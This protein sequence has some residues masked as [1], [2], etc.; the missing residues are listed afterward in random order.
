MKYDYLLNMAYE[1]YPKGID[2]IDD[3]AK[4]LLSKE[5]AKLNKTIKYHSEYP[6]DPSLDVF[7]SIFKKI[8]KEMI[9]SDA[10]WFNWQD[11]C[12]TFE[13]REKRGNN[14]YTIRFY[15]SILVP[16]FFLKTFKIKMHKNK[17]EYFELSHDSVYDK[18]KIA[19]IKKAAKDILLVDEFDSTIAKNIIEDINF[20]DIRLG[21]FTLFNAFFSNNII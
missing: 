14:I 2:S 17:K 5:Y 11:R 9:F 10:T 1:F 6:N 20:E 4:Y 8:G 16:Y 3:K 12:Y 15:K 7:L 18:K 13:L 21:K 19:E